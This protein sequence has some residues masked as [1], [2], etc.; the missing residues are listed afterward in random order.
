MS[1]ISSFIIPWMS[2]P[3][4]LFYE[5]FKSHKAQGGSNFKG[6]ALDIKLHFLFKSVSL[7]IPHRMTRI[8]N[9]DEFGWEIGKSC[10]FY[11]L[12]ANSMEN[13]RGKL[14]KAESWC[15]FTS[16]WK[17]CHH[18]FHPRSVALQF[19]SRWLVIDPNYA[20]QQ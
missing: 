12:Y 17:L 15:G 14:R 10:F 9:F 5:A 19:L 6:K 13:C 20:A 11:F 16:W 1:S 2:L 8:K 3:L 7:K 4:Q 18:V